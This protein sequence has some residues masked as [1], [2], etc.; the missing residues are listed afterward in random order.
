MPT[1]IPLL[2][3]LD[4]SFRPVTPG[5]RYLDP[6]AAVAAAEAVKNQGR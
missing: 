5:G 3:E 6:E 1:G 4:A 2:Y